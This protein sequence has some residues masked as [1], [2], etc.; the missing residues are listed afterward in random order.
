MQKSNIN[1]WKN[2]ERVIN[3]DQ[4]APIF[5]LD[6]G[7]R[8]IIGV[9]LAPLTNGEFEVKDIKIIEHDERSML[10]G[11]IHDVIAVSNTI[12]KVKNQLESVHGSLNKVSVAA[13]GRSLKTK[14]VKIDVS[15][16]GQPILRKEDIRGLEL[17]AVQEAQKQLIEDNHN[18][19]I[20]HYHCV[21]YSVVNYYIDNQIIGNLIDQRGKIAS[22]EIIAT[23]LPRVVVDSLLSSLKRAGLT[24]EALTLEPIAAIHVLIPPS[25]RKLNIAFVD[26]G[27]G[28]SDI[29]ITDEGTI[30]A[31][32][33]VP[34]AGDEITEAVSQHFL[35]DFNIAEGIKRELN[36]EQEITF[37]DILGM[38]YTLPSSVMVQQINDAIENLA[39]HIGEKIL[40]LNKKSPQAVMLVGGGSQT[41]KLTE[42]LAEFLNI[43]PQRVG[44]RGADA[45]QQK[46]SWPEDNSKGPELITPIGIGISSKENPIQYLTFYVNGDAIHLFEMKALTVGDALIAAGIP[47]KTL[48]GK[49]G[50]ALT[51]KINGKVK[52]VPGEHGTLPEIKIN[53]QAG[54][55]DSPIKNGDRINVAAGKNGN[56]AV[57]TVEKAMELAGLQPYNIVIN[58]QKYQL[59][60]LVEV[61]GIDADY[62]STLNDRDNID[63][64]HIKTIEE[65]LVLTGQSTVPFTEKLISFYVMN[66]KKSVKYKQ[67]QLYRNG[68]PISLND[69]IRDGDVITF[70]K[71]NVPYPTIKDV[72]EK[73]K[74]PSQIITVTFNGERV[75]IEPASFR[76][77]MNQGNVTLD[78][79]IQQD[80]FIEI[81]F[82]EESL[83]K[84]SDVFRYVEFDR[85]SPNGGSRYVLK[86]NGEQ[87]DFN[88]PIVHGDQLELYWE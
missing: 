13:A 47:V 19:D 81:T 37:T 79:P 68:E 84:F 10:D 1:M 24:M 61:N 42:K 72:I 87:A 45:I 64:N 60:P 57:L 55:I 22:V 83:L 82:S 88:T 30:V 32:G 39:K 65:A 12:A 40:E 41:P 17:S 15:I 66:E 58:N 78:T 33:M 71:D 44:V 11:Q 86:V 46:V 5:A 18:E 9:I 21:G 27:A 59:Q 80:S 63:F 85:V 26:I 67:K 73:D 6:I 77:T 56:D 74:L 69:M 50:M 53:D 38:T 36:T 4:Q 3:L 20:G 70:D 52:M 31:Y 25:M 8:S 29:A 48:F 62:T 34:I 2:V 75:K 49:P 7:T 16:D 54:T 76:I 14:R 35:L 43:T 28:T 51:V 23:F